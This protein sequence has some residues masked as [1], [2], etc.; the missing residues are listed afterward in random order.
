MCGYQGFGPTVAARKEGFI[1][2]FSYH[3][4]K[5]SHV[6]V[7]HQIVWEGQQYPRKRVINTCFVV[8]RTNY[9][10]FFAFPTHVCA[11]KRAFNVNTFYKSRCF[12]FVC[13]IGMLKYL[14]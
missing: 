4:G 6:N 12:L 13:F 11:L 8:F 2:V 7:S 10:L 14:P 3:D 5:Y 9:F 1:S